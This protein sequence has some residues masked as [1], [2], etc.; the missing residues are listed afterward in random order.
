MI[1]L[2]FGAAGF[3]CGLYFR[4][5]PFVILMLTAGA[6]YAATEL[7]WSGSAIS[8]VAL[9]VVIALISGQLG[10]FFS[11][12]FRVAQRKRTL[13]KTEA[14]GSASDR[15]AVRSSRETPLRH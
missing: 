9:R 4:I 11:V 6:G 15:S 12:L 1:G 5:V 7:W 2:F 10:Y 13:V 3:A 8:S 14:N